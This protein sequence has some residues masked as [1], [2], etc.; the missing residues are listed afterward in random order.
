M[1]ITIELQSFIT[2]GAFNAIARNAFLDAGGTILYPA[3]VVT[4]G[5]VINGDAPPTEPDWAMEGKTV[6]NPCGYVDPSTIVFFQTKEMRNGL[7]IKNTELSDKIWRAGLKPGNAN[8]L[9]FLEQNQGYLANVPKHINCLLATETMFN[10]KD[11][12]GC[13]IPGK[14]F[15]CLYRRKSGKWE[16]SNRRLDSGCSGDY[17]RVTDAAVA[18]PL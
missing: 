16:L 10:G 18:F 5:I 1:K 13:G 4:S 2:N 7:A 14:S 9:V 17:S 3:T 12:P 15:S 8:I 6:Q 11:R